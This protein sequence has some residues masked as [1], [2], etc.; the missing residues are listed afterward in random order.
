MRYDRVLDG[1]CSHDFVEAANKS[2]EF[3]GV[4]N[5]LTFFTFSLV[6]HGSVLYHS[7]AKK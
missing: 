2:T 4:S 3:S 7:P 6:G 1:S 5:Y